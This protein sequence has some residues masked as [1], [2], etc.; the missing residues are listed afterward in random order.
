MRQDLR[1]W[2]LFTLPLSKFSS[3]TITMDP[4]KL[5]KNVMTVLVAKTF[6]LK[7][8]HKNQRFL[9]FVLKKRW[10]G[11]CIRL[12]QLKSLNKAV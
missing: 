3:N 5:M 10:K 8:A 2:F 9:K 4:S 7:G 11:G 12:E 6:K 1:I